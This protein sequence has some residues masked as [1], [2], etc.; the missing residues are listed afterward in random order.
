MANAKLS[1]RLLV[2]GPS[3]EY[4]VGKEISWHNKEETISYKIQNIVEADNGPICEYYGV[5]PLISTSSEGGTFQHYVSLLLALDTKFSRV[6]N[7][8]LHRSENPEYDEN[9]N[10]LVYKYR[11]TKNLGG[12]I[13]PIN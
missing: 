10:T 4:L 12:S 3:R 2:Q 7:G 13:K 5:V 6:I 8:V 9:T 1:V 11:M